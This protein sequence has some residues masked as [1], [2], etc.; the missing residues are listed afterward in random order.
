MIR[1]LILEAEPFSVENDLMTPT[2]KLKRH[3]LQVS[4]SP[5]SDTRHNLRLESFVFKVCLL[6]I[7]GCIGEGNHNVCVKNIHKEDLSSVARPCS[8]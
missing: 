5:F 7:G 1:G 4:T 2:F 8:T 6:S 3:Q